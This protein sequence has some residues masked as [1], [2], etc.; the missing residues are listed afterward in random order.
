MSDHAPGLRRHHSETGPLNC[1]TVSE[2][3]WDHQDTAMP[4]WLGILTVVLPSLAF[5]NQTTT[6]ATCCHED[7]SVNRAEIAAIVL[8]IIFLLLIGGAVVICIL[9]Y[10]GYLGRDPEEQA[11]VMP[12]FPDIFTTPSS[13]RAV[14]YQAILKSKKTRQS[15]LKNTSS[16]PIIYID[17]DIYH[18]P[19]SRPLPTNSVPAVPYREREINSKVHNYRGS[20]NRQNRS[21]PER[22]RSRKQKSRRHTKIVRD[23]RP[24]SAPAHVRE[25]VHSDGLDEDIIVIPDTGRSLII[26]TDYGAKN[27]YMDYTV[28]SKSQL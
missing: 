25:R 21:F 9:F 20:E 11:T 28:L 4:I 13:L 15:L 1:V 3:R 18:P 14:S 6:N 23:I 16:E 22:K 27:P 10:K 5:A 26:T 19:N 17:D 24:E 12:L 2:L 8:G 7:S